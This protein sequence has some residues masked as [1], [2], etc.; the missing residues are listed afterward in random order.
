MAKVR[1]ATVADTRPEPARRAY[2]NR[3]ITWRE[4]IAG[5]TTKRREEF[6]MTAG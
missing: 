6:E 1:W 3:L 2:G 4:S 5:R